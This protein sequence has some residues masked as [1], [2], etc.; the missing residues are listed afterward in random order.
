MEVSIMKNKFIL[1]LISAIALVGGCNGN[2]N[3]IRGP[4]DPNE[5]SGE[6]ENPHLV[7]GITIT[8]LKEVVEKA[9]KSIFDITSYKTSKSATRNKFDPETHEPLLDHNYSLSGEGKLYSNSVLVDEF[10]APDQESYDLYFYDSPARTKGYFYID[11]TFTEIK[12]RYAS[13]SDG[14]VKEVKY[15]DYSPVNYEEIFYPSYLN[16]MSTVDLETISLAGYLN[17]GRVVFQVVQKHESSYVEYGITYDVET[18]IYINYL[19]KDNKCDEYQ[20]RSKATYTVHDDPTKSYVMGET[21]IGETYAYGD[22]GEF[23]KTTF[24][25]LSE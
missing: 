20:T 5:D 14:K 21:L 11:D 17:D 1:L 3:I 12:L 19:F 4:S 24:P 13:A 8:K 6:V 15:R 22:N 2:D 10:S 23:D 7:R 18:I 9:S 16:Q 25:G